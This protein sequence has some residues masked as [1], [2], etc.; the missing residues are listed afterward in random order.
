MKASLDHVYIYVS[1][2]KA[3]YKFYKPLLTYLGFKEFINEDWGF[4]FGNKQDNNGIIFEETSGKYTQEGYHRK[5]AGLNHL[6]FRVN[7]KRAVNQF[8]KEYLQKHKIQSP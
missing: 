3:A 4:G 7:S 2:R 5:R 1:D 6:A 8:Y